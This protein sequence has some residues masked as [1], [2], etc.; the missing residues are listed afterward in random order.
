MRSV[1]SQFVILMAMVFMAAALPARADGNQFAGVLPNGPVLTKNVESMQAARYRNLVRQQ[2][3]YSC[4][5]ASLATILRYAYGLNVDETTVIEGMMG[6]ADPAVVQE[7]GFSLLDIKR[8]VE[9]LGMRGRGYR[10]DEERLGTLR[11]PGL[12][13]MDVAGFR[14][15]VVLKRIDDGLVEVGDPI[16]GNRRIP[17]K[18][19]LEA[20]PSRAVFVVIGSDFDRN[21]V[22]LQPSARPSARALYA[23]QGPITDAELLDFGFT[24]ADL[25]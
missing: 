1:L 2:T 20:W 4:G 25:F 24:H 7:R 14:H 6:V 21:T 11:V 8:Y 23:R 15:F 10:V 18:E 17:M 9:T 16:L 12:I 22:L 5:A 3:D 19:F 13:L